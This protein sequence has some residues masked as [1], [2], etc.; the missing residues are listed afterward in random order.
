MVEIKMVGEATYLETITCKRSFAIQGV[1]TKK[2]NC[3]SYDNNNNGRQ[4][5]V[6]N[7]KLRQPIVIAM[8]WP[9]GVDGTQ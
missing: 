6:K 1:S 7:Y 2:Y 4:G 9:H 3:I 8:D 5:N